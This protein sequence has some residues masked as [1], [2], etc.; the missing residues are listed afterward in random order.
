VLVDERRGQ[1]RQR[2]AVEPVEDTVL[3]ALGDEEVG[4]VV[5]PGQPPA[6]VG[7]L[8]PA[9]VA[10]SLEQLEDAVEVAGEGGVAPAHLALQR[11]ALALV[12]G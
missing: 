6:G 3:E 11:A 12:A 1:P 2:R 8:P 9:Q 4:L 5:E 7:Q 10:P